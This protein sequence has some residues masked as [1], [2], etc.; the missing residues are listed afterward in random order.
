MR[1]ICGTDF[2]IYDNAAA[3]AAG[4]LAARLALPLTLVHVLDPSR[5][6]NPSPDLM[7]YL[8]RA[9]QKKLQTLAERAGRKGVIVETTIVEGLPA[10]KLAELAANL[11]ARFLVVSAIGQIA[12]TQ[13]LA[14]SVADQAVQ[15]S[16]VPTLVLRDPGSFESWLN[17]ER[18]LKVL[19]GYD[20]SASAEAAV[21]WVKSIEGIAP[22]DITIAYVASPAKERSRLG[23]TPPLSGLYY[24]SALR[25]LLEE[26]IRQ[27]CGPALGNRAKIVVRSDWGR[28]DSQ[29]IEMAAD[30][31]TDLMVVGGSARRGLAR[32]GSVA[33]GVV[34]HAR[35]NVASVPVGWAAPARHEVRENGLS[36]SIGNSALSR[37]IVSE[38]LEAVR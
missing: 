23:I 15:L 30:T 6:S 25:K 38:V 17:G 35:M 24:P 28:P 9:R 36:N 3:I 8:R 27:K 4:S 2:S 19:V 33:R 11:Q 37:E 7:S 5:Y 31:G 34:H 18:A 29:L 1:I 22:C 21:R 10:T 13:W 14:G 16:P 26:E 12:P 20:F 32:F